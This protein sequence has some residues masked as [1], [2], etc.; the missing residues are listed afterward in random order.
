MTINCKGRLIDLS[1]PKVMGILNSTPDSF[2]E[3]SRTQ[4]KS[5]IL[6]KAEMM[7]EEGATFIDIGG[8]SSRPDA[9]NVAENEELKRVVPAIELL[10]KEFPEILISV[11]TFR[12]KVAEE[13]IGAGAALINDI[14]AGRLDEKMMSII[15][16]HQVPYIMMHMRGTPKTMK[17]LTA[18][19][20]LVSDI[21][22]YFSEKIKEARTL[23]I[24]DLI[25]DPGFG[26]AKTTDQNFELL[27]K[28]ALFSSFKLPVLIGI[29][30]KT[31]IHKTL[32]ISPKK[33]LNGTTVLN[34][35]ALTKGAAIL[36]VHDV[37]EAMETIKLVSLFSK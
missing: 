21:T 20:D 9:E 8:Y 18:Y 12:S 16:Q 15:A 13:A 26:F 2:F 23:G 6:K 4:N 36:R 24:N 33:A 32:N 25:L 19:D 1:S 5:D 37:K 17:Q 22:Y 27:K 14:S 11:D 7:L 30:R 35:L 29:S 28:S 31:M 10:V 3:D 34:T